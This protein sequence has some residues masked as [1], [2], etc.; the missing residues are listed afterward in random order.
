MAVKGKSENESNSG[1]ILERKKAKSTHL[2]NM[3][4]ERKRSG[5]LVFSTSPQLLKP[6]VIPCLYLT[7]KHGEKNSWQFI[8]FLVTILVLSLTS[9]EGGLAGPP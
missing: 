9:P 8:S 3:A 1:H 2:L 5:E 4:H 6:E 7:R